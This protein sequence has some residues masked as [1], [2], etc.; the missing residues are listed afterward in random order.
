MIRSPEVT[1]LDVGTLHDALPYLIKILTPEADDAA[2]RL[3]QLEKLTLTP[4]DGDRVHRPHNK[5]MGRALGRAVEQMLAKR[6][7]QGSKLRELS[8]SE[9]MVT[10]NALLN[11]LAGS[12]DIL[13][14]TPC[15]CPYPPLPADVENPLNP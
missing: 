13:R 4:M 5:A 14:R 9:C 1:K 2:V 11:E 15:D 6:V 3:P 10:S 12:T 8:V 7:A